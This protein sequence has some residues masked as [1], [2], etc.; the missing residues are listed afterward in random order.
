MLFTFFPIKVI[1]DTDLINCD[2]ALLKLLHAILDGSLCAYN[3]LNSCLVSTLP[4]PSLNLTIERYSY[5]KVVIQC[6]L[7]LYFLL[8]TFSVL[9]MHTQ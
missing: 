1:R 9:P 5:R 2:L 8:V 4:Y 6:P 3:Q 7:Y